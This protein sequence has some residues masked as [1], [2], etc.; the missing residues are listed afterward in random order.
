MMDRVISYHQCLY[1]VANQSCLGLITS[2][3]LGLLIKL[4]Q[5]RIEKGGISNTT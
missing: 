5:I 2:F 4:S 1:L 3:A